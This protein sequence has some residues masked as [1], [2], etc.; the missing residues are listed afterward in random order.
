[1]TCYYQDIAGECCSN[2]VTITYRC[3][4]S[5]FFNC[6]KQFCLDGQEKTSYHCGV[7]D[8][9]PFGCNCAGGCRK[10]YT[11]ADVRGNII[12]ANPNIRILRECVERKEVLQEK[13]CP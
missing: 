9:D 12:A 13:P 5:D 7:G 2:T 4:G 6:K 10:G 8:C 3:D 1:M 11:D